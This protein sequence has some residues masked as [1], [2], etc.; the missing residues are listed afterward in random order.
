MELRWYQEEAVESLFD[1]FDKHGGTDVTTGLPVR[2]NPVVA[3]PTGTGKSVVIA[4]F[5]RRA[6]V[7]YPQ[8]R[9]V[10]A[11]HVKELIKQNAAKMQQVWPVAPLGIYSAGLSSRDNIQPIIFGGIKSMVAKY[12]IFG[13]RDFLVVD[14]AHL[15]SPNAD[16]SYIK[17]IAEL[18]YGPDFDPSQHEVTPQLVQRAMA[19][20]NCNPYLKVISL[21]ATP[22]RLGLGHITNGRIATDVCYNLCTIDGFNRLIAEGYLSPLI[23]KRTQTEL[24]VSGVGI[25]GGEFIAGQLE[26]AV[27][28]QDVTYAALREA[29]EYGHDRA[30][31]LIFASGIEHAEHICD[32]LNGVFGIPTVVIH[33][34]NKQYPRTDKQNDEALKAWKTGKVRAAVNMNSL[35]TGVDHPVTDFILCMRPSNSTGLW[36]Q[37]LGRGTRPFDWFKLKPDEQR[38]LAA[39]QGYVKQNCLVLDFAGNTRRLGPINDPVVPKPKGQ[40]A[41]GD[42]PVRICPQCSTYCHA[43]VKFCVVC[44]YEFKFDPGI[45]RS[46]GTDELLRSDLPQVEYFAVNR[47]VYSPHTSRKS[48]NNTI[49]VAYYCENLRTFYEWIT[50][51]GGGF[52]AKRGRDWFRQ[53]YPGEPP[54]TNADVLKYV[55]ELRAPARIRVWV[56]R[57]YPEVLGYEF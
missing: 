5:F 55:S 22:Y 1:Y 14:E 45:S 52:A 42:A 21:T 38:E 27:D 49:Q 2:A 56:N 43:T 57:K 12:P 9:G 28:K 7:R 36:V 34:G 31:W 4:E 18:M 53:R 33:S 39:F 37:M 13:F 29:V 44:G 35:T 19:N 30:S 46:A 17:F 54:E 6:L 48:G 16:T 41:P 40:G 24:D 15:I 32:M 47:A 8:T 51:E 50:V 3:L 20:R 23:P 25:S 26:A 10:M 11:T